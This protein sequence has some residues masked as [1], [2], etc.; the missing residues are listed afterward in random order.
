MLQKDLILPPLW[1]RL[2]PADEKMP[3]YPKVTSSFFCP[4]QT[5]T[6]GLKM[7]ESKKI[8]CNGKRFQNVTIH[9]PYLADKGQ[10]NRKNC[11]ERHTYSATDYKSGRNI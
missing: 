5:L 8:K 1:Q 7:K 2:S 11:K 6:K 9:A 10:N 4:T 3:L